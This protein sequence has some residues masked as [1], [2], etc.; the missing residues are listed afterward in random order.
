MVDFDKS[1]SQLTI[2]L[3]E[4]EI[5]DEANRLVLRDTPRTSFQILF[6]TVHCDRCLPLKEFVLLMQTSNLQDGVRFLGGL[7]W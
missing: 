2:L 3:A 6:V 4:V 5:T 1:L 7:L